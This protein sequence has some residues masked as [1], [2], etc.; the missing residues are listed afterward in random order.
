MTI[1][2]LNTASVRSVIQI[3]Q[4]QIYGNTKFLSISLVCKAKTGNRFWAISDLVIVG[5]QCNDCV[6]TKL[7]NTISRIGNLTVY[8]VIVV[9]PLL[10][11]FV[12][13]IRVGIY[14]K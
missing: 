9:V 6:T 8:V 4:Y 14:K 2:S 3:F 1:S 12:I 11:L 10:I 7:S 13:F 5:K